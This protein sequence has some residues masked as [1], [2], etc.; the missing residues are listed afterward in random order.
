MLSFVVATVAFAQSTLP[1][2]TYSLS[3]DAAIR[4]VANKWGDREWRGISIGLSPAITYFL[5]DQ[6]AITIHPEMMLDY[7]ESKYDD[8]IYAYSD[9][10]KGVEVGIMCGGKYY[11]D[12]QKINPYLGIS[13][14]V[15]WNNSDPEKFDFIKLGTPH[16]AVSTVMGIAFFI[17]SSVALDPKISMSYQTI[18]EQKQIG[19]Y[20]GV[21]VTYFIKE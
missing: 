12:L 5:V 18:G 13:A 14:G 1:A 4:S 17:N 2:G 10:Y 7:Y 21:G 9:E 11:I 6:L 15:L 8:G 20:A 3:G 16:V 19:S